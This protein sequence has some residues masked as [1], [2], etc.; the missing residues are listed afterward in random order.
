MNMVTPGLMPLYIQV[1]N[2]M[3]DNVVTGRWKP[4]R[5]LSSE[6]VLAAE[7]RVSQ[8]T[9]RKALNEM[10]A[11]HLVVRKQGRGTFVSEHSPQRSL[12]HFFHIVADEGKHTLPTSTVV[13]QLTRKATNNETGKLDLSDKEEIYF[14]ERVRNLGGKPIILER[15][16]LPVK[17]FPGLSFPINEEMS[18]ELYV[19]YQRSYNVIVGKAKEELKATGADGVD[20]RLLGVPIGTPLLKIERVAFDLNSHPVELRIGRCSTDSYHYLN[21][22]D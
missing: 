12:F 10:E 20:S 8:G 7:L 15:L 9:V 3:I 11:Q 19:L 5:M 2:I 17:L 6:S 16:C 13:S 4:G 1:K 18:E 22:I 21:E 14:I